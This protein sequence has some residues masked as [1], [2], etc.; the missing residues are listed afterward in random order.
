MSSRLLS[1]LSFAVCWPSLGCLPLLLL[2][3]SRVRFLFP[4][5]AFGV[6]GL[7]LW[8]V[9]SPVLCH[10]SIT[11]FLVVPSV[12]CLGFDLLIWILVGSWFVGSLEPQK[13]KPISNSAFSSMLGVRP[14]HLVYGWELGNSCSDSRFYGSSLNSLL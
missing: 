14:T 13:Y 3:S 7:P 1:I 12:M 5:L 6:F 2:V 8:S 9:G 10:E 4:R 11:L